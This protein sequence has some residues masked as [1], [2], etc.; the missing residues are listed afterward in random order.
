M[1]PDFF[2]KI[3]TFFH[4]A[5]GKN[6]KDVAIHKKL[7]C[8]TLITNWHFRAQKPNA[9]SPIDVLCLPNVK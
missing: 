9:V 3:A 4:M 2:T 6:E 7:T 1:W 5:G 8:S